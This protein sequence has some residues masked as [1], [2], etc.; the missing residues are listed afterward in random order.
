MNNGF[1]YVFFVRL[2]TMQSYSN[3]EYISA[4]AQHFFT[5]L[6]NYMF[7]TDRANKKEMAQIFHASGSDHQEYE[8]LL[9]YRPSLAQRITNPKKYIR[10]AKQ[11]Y[12]KT[13]FQFCLTCLLSPVASEHISRGIKLYFFPR[14]RKQYFQKTI[15]LGQNTLV[16]VWG[17]RAD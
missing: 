5:Y 6:K 17:R 13:P 9:S 7:L 4:V 1:L 3:S 14:L 10:F 16:F 8:P 2:K 12:W 11:A 15:L